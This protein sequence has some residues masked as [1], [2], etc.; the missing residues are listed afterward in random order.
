MKRQELIFESNSKNFMT[1]FLGR[2]ITPINKI[3]VS[4][5][6]SKIQ[7]VS[8]QGKAVQFPLKLAFAGTSHK[9]Q[10]LTIL[11]P[12]PLI[13]DL[14]YIREPA[15]AYVML[16]RVQDISQFEIYSELNVEK[17]YHCPTALEEVQRLS[18]ISKTTFT[19][20]RR[21][22]IAFSFMNIY[23]QKF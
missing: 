19:G 22:E 15:Q 5:S 7:S 21:E 4:Y 13:V 17:L 18:S 9:V 12:E 20:R 11:K 2:R 8:N 1:S 6:L 10:G 14:R 23:S 16:S 3:E